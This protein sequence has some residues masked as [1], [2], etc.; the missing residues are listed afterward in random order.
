MLPPNPNPNPN[1]TRQPSLTFSLRT[2]N[3]NETG[4]SHASPRSHRRQTSQGS[5]HVRRL[6][7]TESWGAADVELDRPDAAGEDSL[8]RDGSIERAA[9]A[10]KEHGYEDVDLDGAGAGARAGARAGKGE[11]VPDSEALNDDLDLDLDI[12]DEDD[13][14]LDLDLEDLEAE[15]GLPGYEDRAR[16]L[17]ETLEKLGFGE[18]PSSL[19]SDVTLYRSSR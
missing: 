12:E 18:C 13:D 16:G 19:L 8:A 10:G 17:E 11:D 9:V 6:S 14:N 4:T 7:D 3:P 1:A 15:E 2:A 5:T